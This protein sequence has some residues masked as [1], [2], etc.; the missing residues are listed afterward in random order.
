MG[1]SEQMDIGS[2]EIKR[3]GSLF[4]KGNP[5]RLIEIS[6]TWKSKGP[7]RN[8]V[9]RQYSTHERLFMPANNI[10][11]KPEDGCM[12]KIKLERSLK[13][14]A[15]EFKNRGKYDIV[16]GIEQGDNKWIGS[17]GRQ[18]KDQGFKSS[19]TGRVSEQAS[20]DHWAERLGIKARTTNAS[21]IM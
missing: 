12:K 21:P 10:D 17:F 6:D 11:R 9:F 20:K 18:A 3:F 13:L 5:D 1:T 15:E 19:Q 2:P 8:S 16:T 14:R 4:S 7:V